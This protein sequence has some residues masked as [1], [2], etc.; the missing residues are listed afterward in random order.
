MK[1]AIGQPEHF[2]YIGYFKKMDYSDIF[3][4]LDNVQFQGRRS[5]QNR[6]RFLNNSGK[7]EWFTV[8]VSKGSYYKKIN[9]VLVAPDYGWKK[10]LVKKM[11]YNFPRFNFDSIYNSERLVE[12]NMNSINLCRKELEITTPIVYSS[13]LDIKGVKGELLFNICKYFNASTYV[14]GLGGKAYLNDKSFENIK[15]EFLDP[16]VDNYDST[17]SYLNCHEKPLGW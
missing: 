1:I 5:F 12:I 7:M 14:S 13:Q 2:P 16:K 6:N 11:S 17:I 10:K 9:E 4:I 3:V 8:P 15:I